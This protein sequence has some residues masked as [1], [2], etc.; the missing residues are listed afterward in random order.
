MSHIGLHQPSMK[1]DRD[2]GFGQLFVFEGPDDVGKSTLAGMLCQHL[3]E[4]GQRTEL[5]SFPGNESGT[6]GEL[7]YRLYH[8]PREFGLSRVSSIAMQLVVTAA[9]IE[10][11]EAR[12]KPLLQAGV[13]VVLDRFWWSTWVYANVQGV[14]Q[15]QRDKM[16]EIELLS[17]EDIKPTFVFLVLRPEP[18]LDQPANHPWQSILAFYEQLFE[19]Q[20]E[21]V[22]SQVVLNDRGIEQAFQA[23]VSHVEGRRVTVPKKA[24]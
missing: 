11:I 10:V 15:P 19:L 22:H 18:F 7:V 12:I 8:S 3:S 20:K 14:S 23:V 13:N 17:W 4:A 5:L 16:I 1:H 21:N 6:L 24:K 2:Q 9:H